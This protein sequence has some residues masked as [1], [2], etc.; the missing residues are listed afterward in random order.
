VT[1]DSDAPS[2]VALIFVDEAGQNSIVV[3]PGA[4]SKVSPDDVEAARPAFEAADIV[5]LQF[6]IPVE[7]VAAAITLS[8]K[9]GKRVILNPAPV[10]PGLPKTFF[11]GVD[12]LTPN[13]FEA[14]MILGGTLDHTFDGA[15]T[16]MELLK[17]GLGTAVV[18]LGP[19]GAI[20]A[21]GDR[22]LELAAP[23]VDAIDT[24]A[25]GDCFAGALAVALGEGEELG[26]ALRFANTAASISVTKMG[27][28]ASMP[29]RA[30]VVAKLTD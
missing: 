14:C 30:E 6:E 5:V 22:I 16:A 13:E 28:Q 9:L 3:A 19:K 26:E 15:K 12:I 29:N 20:A 2:G 10:P 8:R 25:A 7:T 24:T 21:T 4:N 27:A 23:S 1:R 11:R 17:Q 18:T